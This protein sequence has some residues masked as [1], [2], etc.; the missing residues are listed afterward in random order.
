M[1]SLRI[2]VVLVA[3]LMAALAM[4]PMVSATG[5]EF[6]AIS[7][8]PYT[9]HFINES[10]GFSYFWNFGDGTTSTEE[11]PTH[12]YSPGTY[13]VSHTTT[14]WFGS[15]TDTIQNFVTVYSDGTK[16]MPVCL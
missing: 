4:V 3:L 2:C 10:G 15:N 5:A 11:N 7:Q 14:G 6:C 16:S 8:G 1:K 13:T 12:V 9:V